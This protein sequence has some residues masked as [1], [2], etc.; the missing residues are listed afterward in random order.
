[1]GFHVYETEYKNNRFWAERTDISDGADMMRVINRYKECTYQKVNGFGGAFT[2]SSGYNLT[3]LPEAVQ[4]EV[5]DAYFSEDG[6]RYNLCRTHINSCDFALDNYAYVEDET[7]TEFKTFDISRDHR[8]I[9]PMILR[10]KEKAGEDLVL[11]ASPWSPPPFMKTNGE[12]NHGGKLKEEYYGAWARYIARY[13]KEYAAIGIRVSMVSVQNEPMAVQTWDSCIYETEDEMRFVCDYLGPVLEEEGLGDVKILV[14]DHN[15][16]ILFE[17][18]D[19]ILKD[20]KAAKYTAGVAFHWYSGDHFEAISMVREKYPDKE[21]YFTEGC[22]EYSRFADSNEV[23]KAEMYAHDIL[24][25]LLAGA[26]GYMDW[27]LLLDELGGPNHVKNFC[28]APVMCD[29]KT[30]TME[31]RLSY[32]YIGHFSRYIRRG[33]VRVATTR[34][35]DKVEA[36]AFQNPDGSLVTVLLNRTEEDIWMSTR[37]VGEEEKGHSFVLKAHSIC[38]VL[39]D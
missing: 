14:W 36:V 7:D 20:E 6:L 39:E 19:G 12:M 38:T 10:A 21:L 2:E 22:V 25:N 32:Y 30:G 16:D 1:M 5:L 31:K 23:Y 3:R 29:T 15:K 9:I 18:A 8:Y 37:I 17:R 24:G 34:F 28:A 33:A 26:N 35:T 27:N 13:I 11:L 4:E